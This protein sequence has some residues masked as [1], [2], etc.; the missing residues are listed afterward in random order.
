MSWWYV[1]VA[2]CRDGSLYC[3]IARNVAARIAEHDAG[4]GAK[5]TRGRGPLVVL[6]VKRFRTKG[7][8][9][10][11]EYAF[12]QLPREKKEAA[13]YSK[14]WQYR[15]TTAS[16]ARRTSRSSTS[17]TGRAAERRARAS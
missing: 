12:K 1:Y 7:R 5:Y 14:R 3:G 10:S 17:R 11:A 16:R 2:R 8:A 15:T 6:L 9:L 4:T 13:I